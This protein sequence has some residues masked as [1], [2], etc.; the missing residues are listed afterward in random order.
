MGDDLAQETHDRL[1]AKAH[2]FGGPLGG[3]RPAEALGAAVA[4]ARPAYV[5][6]DA[7][8]HRH[9]PRGLVPEHGVDPALEHPVGPVLAEVAVRGAVEASGSDATAVVEH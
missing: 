3:N 5:V 7:D 2:D 1:L 6:V 4:A 9:D 8:V